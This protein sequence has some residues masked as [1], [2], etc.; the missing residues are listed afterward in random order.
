[1]IK[2][3]GS[4]RSS[5]GRC[6]VML[7][8][9]GLAY[10]GVSLDLSERREHKSPEYMKLNPNGKVPCLVDG[11][12]VLWES[13]AIVQYL[14]EKYK[15]EM[16]GSSPEDRALVQQWAFWTMTEAQPPLV[17]LLIQ[18]LF[19]PEEKRNLDL[20]ARREKQVPGLLSVLDNALANKKYLV[21][22]HYSVA[23][24]M[25]ASAVNIAAGLQLDLSPFPHIRTWFH[26][27]KARPAWKAVDAKRRSP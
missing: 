3:Y 13:A 16:M 24:L 26:E 8:E 17:D 20:I 10:E 9:A 22:D 18:K 1:M 5:A 2:I 25:A 6:Y 12:F 23:D 21:K 4:P 7:E 11:D 19:V 15:P 14:A 27:I